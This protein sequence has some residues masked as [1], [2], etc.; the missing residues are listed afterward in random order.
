MLKTSASERR[1]PPIRTGRLDFFLGTFV[2]A[3]PTYILALDEIPLAI[4]NLS[5]ASYCKQQYTYIIRYS[6]TARYNWLGHWQ[7]DSKYAKAV[8]CLLKNHEELMHLYVFPAQLWKSIERN[9]P[10]ESTIG[11]IK[12]RTKLVKGQLVRDDYP[13]F[14]LS[15]N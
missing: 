14:F 2:Y 9:N 7:F 5:T 13:T 12:H 11:T 8:I 4:V 6:W 3:G 1:P 15:P 10:I